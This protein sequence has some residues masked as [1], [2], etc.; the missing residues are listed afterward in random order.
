MVG[1]QSPL[2]FFSKSWSFLS[3]HL[4][5]YISV[6]H[7][8][9][10]VYHSIT[11]H[12]SN[13]R[14]KP[15]ANPT[16]SGWYATAVAP[17]RPSIKGEYCSSFSTTSEPDLHSNFKPPS[18][19]FSSDCSFGAHANHLD[20]LWHSASRRLPSSL[21][22]QKRSPRRRP[23]KGSD[24]ISPTMDHFIEMCDLECWDCVVVY[25]CF[26]PLICLLFT[27]HVYIHRLLPHEWHSYPHQA[28]YLPWRF[29]SN[30]IVEFRDEISFMG[31]R[32]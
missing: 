15:S 13:H 19:T 17:W 20:Q 30:L 28:C 23:Q 16:T 22:T 4:T 10:V 32:L 27:F 24:P 21:V 18:P 12:R 25:A 7:L 2:V 31:A 26:A 6:L 3:S 14:S 9:R 5:A 1:T 11:P 8:P 29:S